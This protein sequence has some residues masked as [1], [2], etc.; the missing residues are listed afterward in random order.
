MGKS[1]QKER[2]KRCGLGVG[3]TNTQEDR[4]RKFFVEVFYKTTPPTPKTNGVNLKKGG[5]D[6]REVGTR[7]GEKS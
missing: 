4:E 7:R 2:Y 3:S 5:L 6:G 1:V